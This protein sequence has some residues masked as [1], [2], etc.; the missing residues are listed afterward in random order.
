[1]SYRL[2]RIGREPV[3]SGGLGGSGCELGCG[4]NEVGGVGA[5]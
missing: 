5:L 3:A 1:M 4:V 2:D